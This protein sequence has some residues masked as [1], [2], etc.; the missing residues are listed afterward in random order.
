MSTKVNSK[1]QRRA[2]QYVHHKYTLVSVFGLTQKVNSELTL[3]MSFTSEL[4]TFGAVT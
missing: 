4:Q 3:L 2:C 1:L